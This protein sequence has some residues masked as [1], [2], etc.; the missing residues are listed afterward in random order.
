MADLDLQLSNARKQ[1]IPVDPTAADPF[2]ILP[3]NILDKIIKEF[4][5]DTILTASLVNKNWY[6][7][8]GSSMT[9]M[10][11]INFNVHKDSKKNIKAALKSIRKYQNLK[12]SSENPKVLRQ[13]LK[14]FSNVKDLE[15]HH[16]IEN[17]DIE[18]PNLKRVKIVTKKIYKNG[19]L[20]NLTKLPEI[21]WV[22]QDYLDSQFENIMI[23]YLRKN[24]N[25]K[26]LLIED[27]NNRDG[28]YLNVIDEDYSKYKFKLEKFSY[29]Y[30]TAIPPL[31]EEIV[32]DFL[33]SQAASL[34]TILFD[35]PVPD[36][37]L[38]SLLQDYPKLTTLGLNTMWLDATTLPKIPPNPNIK[39]CQIF[40]PL[41]LKMRY[42]MPLMPN[43]EHLHVDRL[44]ENVDNV[45]MLE[46]IMSLAP[47]SLKT[48]GY[49][50]GCHKDLNEFFE[51]MK[52]AFEAF[53]ENY[54]ADKLQLV[55]INEK[56]FLR[57]YHFAYEPTVPR[58]MRRN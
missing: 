44:R 29:L 28:C 8:I 42:L 51:D 31:E 16:D 53:D 57:S 37:V 12:L 52:C 5:F 2:K 47:K 33:R 25:L 20:S 54:D 4:S 18:L 30:M 34:T 3:Q 56:D 1:T 27:K 11:K 19:I 24:S 38:L 21:E 45:N 23:D 15:I 43:L 7:T 26:S 10:N 22:V 46:L 48:I 14:R 50:T 36:S 17:C 58:R 39:I 55:V 13:F 35:A 32:L 41:P 6:T 40:R 49:V 9:C